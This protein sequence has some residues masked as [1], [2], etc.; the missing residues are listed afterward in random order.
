[1]L[2]ILLN[3]TKYS[4]MDHAKQLSCE[5][6]LLTPTILLQIFK[7]CIPQTS[8][9]PFLKILSN[10]LL[11]FSLLM[12]LSLLSFPA[13]TRF[14]VTIFNVSCLVLSFRFLVLIFSRRSEWEIRS[15]D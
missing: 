5:R 11:L 12:L 8:L 13:T 6:Q 2:P 10:I 9:G 3:E 15:A 4:R 14:L 1:M 7:R